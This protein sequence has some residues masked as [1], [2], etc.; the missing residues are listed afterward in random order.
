M[1]RSR[2]LVLLVFLVGRICDAREAKVFMT[3]SP[4][5]AEIVSEKGHLNVKFVMGWVSKKDGVLY[6]IFSIPSKLTVEAGA[7]GKYF[8]GDKLTNAWII[9][10]TDISHD[11]NRPWGAANKTLLFQVPADTADISFTLKMA[12]Y[13]DDRFKQLIDKFQSN[14]P[15]TGIAVEPYLT[16]AKVADGLFS[17]LFGTDKTHFPFLIDTGISDNGVKSANG[18]YEH[19]IIAIAPNSD[20]D[21]WLQSVDGTKLSYDD[22][23]KDLKYSGQSVKDH[24]YAIIMIESAP[25]LNIAKLM[26]ESNAAWAV[27]ATTNFYSGGLPDISSKDDVAK[28]DKSM[29]KQLAACIDQ[30]KRELRFSAY[31]RAKGL[32]AFS[33]QAKKMISAACSAAKTPIASSDCKT[34]EIDTFETGIGDT[35]GLKNPE[36]KNSLS[37]AAKEVNMQLYQMLKLE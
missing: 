2:V 32:M 18:I 26:F 27:L 33:E 4:N 12:A 35:F 37:P 6:K 25:E 17:T 5:A 29:A 14:E 9:E 34:P 31:D 22:G 1:N 28:Q 13:Q 36:T 11:L 21:N 15:G 24:T 16:Y 19:Y 20:K 30:L 3:K 10:N 8:D 7:T 23:S